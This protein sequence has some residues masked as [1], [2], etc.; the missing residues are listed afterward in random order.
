MQLREVLRG[1]HGEWLLDHPAYA[2]GGTWDDGREC[3]RV[4]DGLRHEFGPD[5]GEHAAMVD[6]RGVDLD[7]VHW[8]DLHGDGRGEEVDPDAGA[9]CGGRE[10]RTGCGKLCISSRPS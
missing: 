2:G 8:D 9:G 3:H 4:G 1:R 10:Y 7:D 5:R 6:Q